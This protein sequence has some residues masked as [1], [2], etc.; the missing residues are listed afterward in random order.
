VTYF[1][2][3]QADEATVRDL[4]ERYFAVLPR[5]PQGP[6]A[7]AL[8]PRSGR[9][10]TVLH[11]GVEPQASVQAYGATPMAWS[12]LAAM[13]VN[14]LSQA[15][16]RALRQELREKENGIYRMRFVLTLNP[17]TQQ[18][19]SEIAFTADPKRMPALWERAQTLLAHPAQAIDSAQLTGISQS[20][21]EAEAKRLTDDTSWFQRLQLSWQQYGD[22]RYL[23]QVPTLAAGLHSADVMTLAHTLDLRRDL[24]SVLV[25]PQ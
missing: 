16:Y 13:Q 21:R 19:E 4:A 10:E 15:L 17:A 23:E 14:V 7:H 24:A 6:V 25:Y 22:A 11:I 5:N 20:L 8:T 18:L 2:A 3:G 9:R 1:L 12:P